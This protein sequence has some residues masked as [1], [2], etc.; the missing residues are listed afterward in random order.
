MCYVRWYV[1]E[2]LMQRSRL[3]LLGGHTM[4]ASVVA[5]VCNM[6]VGGKDVQ[7]VLKALWAYR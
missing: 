1:L 7:A 5:G 4:M 6:D 2:C 3:H